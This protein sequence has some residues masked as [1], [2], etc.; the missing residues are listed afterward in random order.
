MSN[1]RRFVP[2]TKMSKRTRADMNKQKRNTWLINPV[3]RTKDSAK[4]YNRKKIKS[5]D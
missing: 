4:I 2:E 3:S 5:N 1:N